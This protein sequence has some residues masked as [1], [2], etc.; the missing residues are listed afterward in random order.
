MAVTMFFCYA[1]EDEPLL[2]RLKTHLRPLQRQGLIDV[3][4]DR[5]ISAGAEWEQDI[6]KH[7]NTAQIILLLVSPAFMDSDYCYKKEMGKAI[8][9]HKRGEARVIPI[10]LHHVLW[11]GS[12]FDKLQVLPTDAKPIISSAWHSSDEAF[13]NV[14]KGISKAVK[15]LDRNLAASNKANPRQTHSTEQSQYDMYS[16]YAPQPQVAIPSQAQILIPSPQVGNPLKFPMEVMPSHRLML[17]VPH[18]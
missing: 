17:L 15:E 10:I 13:F 2:N 7:L 1:H 11:E 16:G 14:V 12:P 5:E 4:Y 18:L 6:D 3:W 9:R 8:E